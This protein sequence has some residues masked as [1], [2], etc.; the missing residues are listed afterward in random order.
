MKTLRDLIAGAT[1]GPWGQPKYDNADDRGGGQWY[2]VGP[3]KVWWPYG[4]SGAASK[5]NAQLIARCSPDTMLL[6]L[7]ALEKAETDLAFLMRRTSFDF[8][9]DSHSRVV[10]A[11]SHLNGQPAKNE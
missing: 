3:I 5:A 2:Q 9:G 4:Q 7:T 8:I 10:T 6:V 1:P 11:L